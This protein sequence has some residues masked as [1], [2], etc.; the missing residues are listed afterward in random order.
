MAIRIPQNQIQYKYTIGKEYMVE[1]TYKEY[2]GYYYEING[3]LFIGKEFDSNAPELIPIP[4]NNTNVSNLF[5]S[6][7]TKASTYAYGK[8]SGIKIDNTKPI[9]SYFVPSEK[10]AQKGETIRYYIQQKNNNLIKE[11]N[12]DNYK[13]LLNNP[14]FTT[15]KIKCFIVADLLNPVGD[16]NYIFDTKELDEAEKIIPGIKTFLLG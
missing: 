9:S 13:S 11:V 1:S 6:L 15:T 2:Q 16:N 7:L 14:I 5:N 4:K 10:D 8:I 3:K 12:E